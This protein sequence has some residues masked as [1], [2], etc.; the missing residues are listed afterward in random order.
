[1]QA[2]NARNFL[3]V[4]CCLAAGAKFAKGPLAA[5]RGVR[6]VHVG[7]CQWV[8]SSQRAAARWGLKRGAQ[9]GSQAPVRCGQ[10]GKGGRLPSCVK[11]MVK[12]VTDRFGAFA[13]ASQAITRCAAHHREC[14]DM[15]I[16]AVHHHAVVI[17][18]QRA[19]AKVGVLGQTCV[20][21]HVRMRVKEAKQPCCQWLRRACAEYSSMRMHPAG[22]QC[23]TQNTCSARVDMRCVPG[24]GR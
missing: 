23:F 5:K 22:D 14:G 10:A 2:S 24:R 3:A 11:A 17:R 13:I 20:L 12:A 8:V 15:P 16:G 18:G 9:L 7:D 6:H 19:R 1:M 4:R 21:Q